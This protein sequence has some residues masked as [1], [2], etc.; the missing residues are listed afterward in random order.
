MRNQ[1]ET[2]RLSDN[3]VCWENMYSAKYLE[4]M[5]VIWSYYGADF[6]TQLAERADISNCTTQDQKHKHKVC[7]Q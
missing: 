7:L 3:T 4:A 2:E 1:P 5:C 6:M